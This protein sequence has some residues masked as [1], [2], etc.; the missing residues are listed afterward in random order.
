L[1][2]VSSAGV[3]AAV[4]GV[5]SDSLKKLAVAV[6]S[7]FVSGARRFATLTWKRTS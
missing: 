7:I 2:T 3:L 4:S 6:L 5:F 1:T